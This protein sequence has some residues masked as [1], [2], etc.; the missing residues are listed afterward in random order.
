[1]TAFVPSAEQRVILDHPLSSLR[2]AAGAG[3]GKTTTVAERVV[4]LVA[5]HGLEPEEILGITFTNKAAEELADRVRRSLGDHVE[6]GREVEVH[7]YHGF[8]AQLLRE[9]GALVGIERDTPLVTPTFSRQMLRSI[10]DS[11]DFAAFDPTTRF[12]VEPVR[13]L[14]SALSDHLL[15]PEDVAIEGDDD[16]WRTRH[17]LLR[18]ISRY[19]DEKRRLGVVD[20]GDLLARA[21]RL[22]TTRPEIRS[23]VA[24]RYRAVVLD[25]YQDTNPA[26]RELLRAL[27]GPA[28]P[29]MAVGDPDQTI[30][31]WRGASLENFDAFPHHFGSPD[32]PAPTLHL[33]GNRRSGPVILDV[34]NM[35]R[36]NIDDRPRPALA[37][38]AGIDSTEPGSITT[39]WLPT[40]THEATWIAETILDLHDGGTAWRDCAILFRKNKD[41]LAVHD[42]LARHDIPFEVA[43]LGGLLGVPEV[44]DLHAWFRV[45]EHPGDGPALVRVLMGGRFRLGMGD[46]A[47]LTRWLRAELAP[48]IDDDA[49]GPSLIE[50]IDHLEDMGGLGARARSAL[51]RFRIEYRILLQAAQGLSLVELAR[52]V[53]DVTG[54]WADLDS[55]DDAAG[56]SAR[57]NLFRFLDLAESWSPLEGR[58]SLR[59]FLDHLAV[60]EHEHTEELDTARLSESDA[61]TLITIHRAKGLE[62][63]VVFLPALYER[64]FPSGT[65]YEDPLRKPEV[66]PYGLR[67]DRESLPDIGP[68]TPEQEAKDLL[69][70]R[71]L[72]QEWRLA[73][74]AA[75]RA[76]RRILASGAWWYGHPEPTKNPVSPSPLLIQIDQHPA[77]QRAV[78]TDQAPDRPDTLGFRSEP[79][80][81]PDPHF[82][83]SWPHALRNAIA[84][85]TWTRRH[86]ATAG[87][88]G[89]Y[90]LR[91][92]EFRQML[93]DLPDLPPGPAAEP[94][95]TSATGLVTYATCP[96]RYQWSEVDRLPRRASAAARRG[97]DVHRRIEL[98]HLGIVPLED[99]T[100]DRYDLAAVDGVQGGAD[101]YSVFL[102]S[103][104]ARR[105][106]LL[107]EAPFELTV[108]ELRVRGRIDAIYPAEPGWEVVDFKSGRRRDDPALRVQLETYAVACSEIEFLDRR[109]DA[110]TATFAYLGGGS[111]VEDRHDVDGAWLDAA[112]AHLDMLAE[113][114]VAERW[115]PTPGSA[116]NG[117]DFIR[118][119]EPGRTY[120]EDAR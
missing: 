74:V 19:R 102:D 60:M 106:P 14:A 79:S 113:G 99:L 67:L 71:H 75:T 97:I 31:E 25:E 90:D 21:H 112:R 57:L 77:A 58:P 116:C 20:Y 104:F 84:D 7:T 107:V 47:V 101:P 44:A 40:V 76:K 34:A 63:P 70:A 103:R 62:W 87:V 105:R 46:L 72:R 9:H 94:P 28:T 4:R 1:M 95:S 54:A 36:A 3:T 10:L 91:V 85:P 6:L 69:R 59:A 51:E 64:N 83:G 22:V 110:L 41:M 80:A 96:K 68:D 11:M 38:A 93:F 16:V 15:E 26:Q 56:L 43:N 42:A 24:E 92:D 82:E 32:G 109:P 27:F 39:A 5:D 100:E 52:T 111:L 13:A 88:T 120:L 78:W 12:A 114:I 98:H 29:V 89:T 81:A 61:V 18:A 48:T 2:V 117:C 49:P 50:A 66:L 17:D 108:G 53:L 73:Y 86:A 35:L 30:Y 37:P 119:C 65:R 55:M 115:D 118:F 23:R 45:L 8:A 33:M